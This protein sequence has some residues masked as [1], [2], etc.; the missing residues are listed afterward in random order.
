MGKGI[1][2]FWRVSSIRRR[3]F[4]RWHRAAKERWEVGGREIALTKHP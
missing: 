3:L 4:A 1:E 2:A